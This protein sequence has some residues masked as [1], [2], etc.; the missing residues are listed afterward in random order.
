MTIRPPAPSRVRL[1]GALALALGLAGTLRAHAI[2]LEAAPAKSSTVA[3]PDVS[4]RLRF[5]SRI[6]GA[7]SQVS[8]VL[9]DR[10]VRAL[11]LDRQTSPD[12]LAA[13]AR[14]LKSG[15]HRLRWQVLASDGHITRGEY[16]FQVR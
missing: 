4:V 7:R 10:G 6:D 5:N 15:A 2:L 14:G 13:R 8:I 11:Q 1:A 3:G 16:G 12:V 9:P